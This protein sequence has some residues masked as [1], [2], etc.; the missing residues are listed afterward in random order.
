LL[1]VWSEGECMHALPGPV[2]MSC[3]GVICMLVVHRWL[4]ES[5]RMGTVLVVCPAQEMRTVVHLK[6]VHKL[7]QMTP[8]RA[9]RKS[10]TRARKFVCDTFACCKHPRM[11]W[12][13]LLLG[14]WFASALVSLARPKIVG[15]R[16]CS[17]LF[18]KLC[19]GLP[20]CV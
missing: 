8:R 11:R 16:D 18:S 3:C 15:L 10:G 19:G 17:M 6:A 9:L 2:E 4:E 7:L 20:L 14:T 5:R 12:S 13:F 1:S